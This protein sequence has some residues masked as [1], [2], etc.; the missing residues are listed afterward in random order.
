MKT[1]RISLCLIFILCNVLVLNAQETIHIS[2]GDREDAT[3]EIRETLMK[4]RSDQVKIIFERG[5]YYCLPDYANEKYCVISNHGNGT[6][7]ILFSLAN[8]KT[9]EIIGNGATLL[10]HG[11]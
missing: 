6:K 5:V 10:F 8:Y 4:S 7:K 1:E 9:I 11:E 2:L 3:C